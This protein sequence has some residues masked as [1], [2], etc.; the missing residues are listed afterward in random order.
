MKRKVILLLLIIILAGIVLDKI[1]IIKAIIDDIKE[2]NA[3]KEE[4]EG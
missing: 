3:N 2:Y 4:D 1:T